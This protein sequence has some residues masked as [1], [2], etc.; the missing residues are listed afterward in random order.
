MDLGEDLAL[1][2][3]E[4][5]DERIAEEAIYTTAPKHCKG[6]TVSCARLP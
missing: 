1:V 2:V 6:L 5:Q 4:K 3:L